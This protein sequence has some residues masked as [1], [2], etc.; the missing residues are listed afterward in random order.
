M[1][2]SHLLLTTLAA[3][4][5]GLV[6]CDR[7]SATATNEAD[8]A[9]ARA[10]AA[11]EAFNTQTDTVWESRETAFGYDA[12]NSTCFSEITG[13]P[14]WGWSIGPL[15]EGVDTF[16]II[17]GAGRCDTA[18]GTKVGYGIVSYEGGVAQV[19]FHAYPGQA[20][21]EAQLYVG[22]DKLPR[23]VKG[24][25][26]VAPGQYPLQ[27]GLDNVTSDSFTVTGLTGN[28]YLVLHL[29]SGPVGSGAPTVVVD[30]GKTGEGDLPGDKG[31]D[32]VKDSTSTGTDGGKGSTGTDG[33]SSS[34]PFAGLD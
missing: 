22:S 28:P 26:T 1:K 17:A 6:G 23:G 5:F 33:G 16:D 25:Y 19:S 34:D 29:V 13:T 12:G 21:F 30:S 4:L 8:E 15:S 14:R 32:D 2:H 7:A 9:A 18:K 3:T 31:T 24:K 11:Q 10:F 20:F 27:H